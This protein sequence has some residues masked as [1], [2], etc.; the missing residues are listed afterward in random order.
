MSNPG[1]ISLVSIKDLPYRFEIEDNIGE[2]IHLH[3]QDIRLDLSIQDFERLAQQTEDVLNILYG[4]KGFKCSDFNETFLFGLAKL[5]PQIEAISEDK[6]PLNEMMV[7][8]FTEEGEHCYRPLEESR[9]MKALRGDQAENDGREQVNLF[10]AGAEI[11]MSNKTRVI[12]NLEYIQKNGY[13]ND[14]GLITLNGADNII[15]D[16]QHRAACLLYLHGDQAVPVRRLHFRERF[17]GGW[18]E[19]S[20]VAFNGSVY[21]ATKETPMSEDTRIDLL[22]SPGEKYHIDLPEGVTELRFDP[23]VSGVF[24]LESISIE[25][26]AGELAFS[27]YGYKTDKGD[28]L[29]GDDPY[30]TINTDGKDI[31][32]IEF[33]AEFG[34]LELSDM[35]YA[36]RN[37]CIQQKQLSEELQENTGLKEYIQVSEKQLKATDE[38]LAK[39]QGW[40][41]ERDESLLATEEQLKKTDEALAKTQNW[42][43]ERDT[44][45]AEAEENYR[46]ADA[47]LQETQ[48]VLFLTEKRLKEKC[49]EYDA[50]VNSF[51]WKMTKPF[52]TRQNKT[53]TGGK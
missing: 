26:D 28:V 23:A 9:V 17:S 13:P 53:G 44:A 8:T 45:L 40:L 2:A 10:E 27:S 5:L 1:V 14:S 47:M 21:Y 29:F 46:T 34:P 19:K 51:A 15:L 32:W 20:T 43:K 33:Q 18:T 12:R 38:A 35:E 4:E 22:W 30:I 16:G 25:S 42:L 37:A 36:F 49:D 39:T 7:D 3:F 31:S 48:K 41:K 11:P 50:I 6:V 52:H 24:L